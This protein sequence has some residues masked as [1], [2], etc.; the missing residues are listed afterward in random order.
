MFDEREEYFKAESDVLSGI[1]VFKPPARLSVVDGVARSVI[2]KQTGGASMPWNVAETPYMAEPMNM[3]ASRHHE[4][5]CFVGPARTGK[6]QGLITGWMAHNAIN[7][8]GDMLIIQMSQDK[9]REFSKTDIDRCI[10]N[11]PDLY[12]L[13][14][15]SA[16]DDN[17]F[18][19][20]FRHGMWL[21]IAWP[22]IGNLS[23]ATYR[24]V[25]F[26]DYD[27]HPDDIGG[28]GAGF[29]L[30]LKRTTTF[31]SR[32]M[33]LVESSPGRDQTDPNW[34][35]A[36]PH[37]APPTGGILGIYN[38]SDR[39]RLYWK[40]MDCREWFEASPGL[41][42]FGLPQDEE[43]LEMVRERDI[44]AMAR[45][46]NRIICPHC[47]SIHIPKQKTELNAKARWL[48][49]G[50]QITVD[51][52]VVGTPVTSTIA[53]F[54]MGGVAAAY[55]PWRSIVSR[56]LQGLRDYALN[57]EELTLQTTVNTDQAMPYMSRHLLEAAKNSSSPA[58]RKDGQL[59]RYTVP[60]EARFLLAGVDVQGGT[61]ARFIVQVHAVGPRNEQWLVDRYSI[62]LSAREG[63]GEQ[64]APIDP[65]RYA[66]DWDQL[67]EKVLRCTYKT[68]VEGRELKIKAVAVD[69]GGEDGVTERAYAWFRRLR[70]EPGAIHRK[71]RLVKG[72]AT[73][74][75][76]LLRETQWGAKKDVP[77]YLLDT[78]R[79]KDAVSTN[80]R[81]PTPGPGFIHWPSWLPNA[82]FDE[83]QAEVR[84]PNGTWK[85]IRSRNEA[86][87]LS[88]YIYALYVLLGCDK[89][90]DWDSVPTWAKPLDEGNADVITADDRREMKENV[91][92]EPE[93]PKLREVKAVE[94]K[95][96]RS[97]YL[98]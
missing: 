29:P 33:C 50:T 84:Q 24:Y 54:W 57:G 62:L 38:R 86:F 48:V 20:M 5:V 49:D 98:S 91:R 10:R 28:E 88:C 92:V 90:R 21:R 3:L 72:V 1:S 58:D 46:Y 41:G 94:R 39:R 30:G 4:A 11:S 75:Q 19:K 31:L 67:T 6:T 8:P 45:E 32:G 2:I 23:G 47:G 26:T 68:S 52:E 71:V 78:D 15:P 17:T 43:L 53:G 93:A 64:F 14:S 56:Y 44:E 40:C 25:A 66:E 89:W 9:A 82:F 80:L 65:A 34:K 51:D 97:N 55:Q 76:T 27:R 87:D 83:L 36:T 35:A 18:D 81:R 37:E 12:A 60:D 16:N 77:G 69:T 85:Q 63:M 95:I 7:D 74:M 73:K 61:N 70:K 42:L 59:K 79:L 13:R 22:T 96:V